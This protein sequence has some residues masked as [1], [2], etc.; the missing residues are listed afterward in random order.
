MAGAAAAFDRPG[1]VDSFVAGAA[2]IVL[3]DF[4][5]PVHANEASLPY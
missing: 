5:I 3:H 2:N 1:A 4:H